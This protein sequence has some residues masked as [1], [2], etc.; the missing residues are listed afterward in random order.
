[1]ISCIKDF[2]KFNFPLPEF[3]EGL[4]LRKIYI[5]Y[6]LCYN[7]KSRDK[8]LK[9]ART[10]MVDEGWSDRKFGGCSKGITAPTLN[11]IQ[12]KECSESLNIF[13]R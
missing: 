12:Q 1:M 3:V 2:Y 10:C 7:L 11:K 9:S 4:N 6:P 8:N 13:W 5:F